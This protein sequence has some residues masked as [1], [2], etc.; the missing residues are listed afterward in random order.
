MNGDGDEGGHNGQ[1]VMVLVV[2]LLTKL[3]LNLKMVVF[4]HMCQPARNIEPF[5]TL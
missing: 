3:K 2:V 4:C 5:F 1:L